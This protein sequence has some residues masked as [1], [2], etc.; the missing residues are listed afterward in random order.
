MILSHRLLHVLPAISFGHF[1]FIQKCTGNSPAG[2]CRSGCACHSA[3]KRVFLAPCSLG[4]ECFGAS[5]GCTLYLIMLSIASRCTSHA[6][7]KGQKKELADR[8][9]LNKGSSVQSHKSRSH[10]GC[11][12]V[13]KQ[14]FVL[15]L[16]LCRL[17]RVMVP[18]YPSETGTVWTKWKQFQ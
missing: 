7:R 18:S 13:A 15:L 16:A 9:I 3:M 14:R 2:L 10:V 5:P 1:L 4:Q 6:E 12:K 8:K 11:M 17:M